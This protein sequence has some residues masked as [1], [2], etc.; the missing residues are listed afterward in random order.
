MH[1]YLDSEGAVAIVI[2]PFR[3]TWKNFLCQEYILARLGWELKFPTL[4]W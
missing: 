3:H 4:S 2:D 1:T